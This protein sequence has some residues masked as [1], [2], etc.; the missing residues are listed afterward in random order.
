MLSKNKNKTKIRTDEVFCDNGIFNFLS[1]DYL[2]AFSMRMV[3]KMA[4]PF[5]AIKLTVLLEV[6]KNKKKKEKDGGADDDHDYNLYQF[7]YF[8]FCNH[9]SELISIIIS[10]RK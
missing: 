3:L 1:F 10:K 6:K 4:C 7:H 8:V 2:R 9:L 5:K